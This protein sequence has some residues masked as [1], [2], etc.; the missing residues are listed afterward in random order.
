MAIADRG[1]VFKTALQLEVGNKYI[2]VHPCNK[3][4]HDKAAPSNLKICCMNERTAQA[5][6]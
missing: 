6:Q 3:K 5:E 4:K 1:H 2:Q